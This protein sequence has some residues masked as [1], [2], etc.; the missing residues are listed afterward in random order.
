V[1]DI[2]LSS[3]ISNNVHTRNQS[4][5]K[6]DL[7]ILPYPFS[8]VVKSKPIHLYFEI[9][10]LN[11]DKD[12]KTNYEISYILKTIQV[13]RNFWQKTIGGIPRLFSNKENNIIST[14]VQREGDSNTAFEYI[15][16]DL[17]NLERGLTELKVSVID[18]NNQQSAENSIE[19]T[20]V[21]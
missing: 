21:K 17:Q 7:S 15:S 5:V 2:Q 10:N 12:N 9:Y 20:L 14:T 6:N 3:N 18:K 11:T 13:E 16:L 1:S 19:F 8:R 4:I